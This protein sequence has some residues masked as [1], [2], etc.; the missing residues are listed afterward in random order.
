MN[1]LMQTESEIKKLK[2][3]KSFGSKGAETTSEQ[4]CLSKNRDTVLSIV[5]LLLACLGLAALA[6]VVV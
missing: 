4:V 1:N 3:Q 5:V 6:H 2:Y